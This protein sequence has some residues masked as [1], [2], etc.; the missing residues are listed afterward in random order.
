MKE[1]VEQLAR[2]AP[3]KQAEELIEFHMRITANAFERASAYNSV[4][5]LACYASFFGLWQITKEFLDPKWGIAAAVLMAIS[6][7][8]FVIFEVAKTFYTSRQILTLQKTM[9]GP[10]KNDPTKLLEEFTKYDAKARVVNIVLVPFWYVSF[11]VSVLTGL[12]ALIILVSVLI[13][14]LLA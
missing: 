11:S 14:A 9:F 13:R 3:R 10:H 4:L 8:S 2:D 12:T 1:V 7:A 5:I 6:A